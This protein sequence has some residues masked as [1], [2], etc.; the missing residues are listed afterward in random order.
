M[1]RFIKSLQFIYKPFYWL[2]FSPYS[3]F[4]D[5]EINKLLDEEILFTNISEYRADLGHLKGLWIDGNCSFCEMNDYMPSR[6]TIQ[7]AKK[8]FKKSI[9][10]Q[11]LQAA[12]KVKGL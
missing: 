6:L 12:K 9:I 8:V 2:K 7:R 5:K 10:E 3:E 11:S 1:I 4:L